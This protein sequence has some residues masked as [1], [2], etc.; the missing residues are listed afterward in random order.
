MIEDP[1]VGEDQATSAVVNWTSLGFVTNTLLKVEKL[2]VS[3]QVRNSHLIRNGVEDRFTVQVLKE[4][5]E[6]EGRITDLLQD[7][8][9]IHPAYPWF[10]QIKGIGLENIGKVVGLINIEKA[11]TI[12]SLW[13]FAGYAVEINQESGIGTAMKL[14]K[15]EKAEFNK[16]LKVM[17]WRLGGSL[18]RAQGSFYDFYL[19][20]KEKEEAKAARNGKSIVSAVKRAELPTEIFAAHIH[21]RALRKMIK[22]FLAMLWM[23]WREAEGLP[24]TQ[25]YSQDILNHAHIFAPADFIDK[26]KKLAKAS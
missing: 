15:G 12:S 2:R 24:V 13:K 1:R 23:A 25:P 22:M 6:F 3:A 8:M 5:D 16:T 26:P 19:Q 14:H 20:A 4:L 9:K 21:N 7:H 11:P 18:M 17:C 10:S